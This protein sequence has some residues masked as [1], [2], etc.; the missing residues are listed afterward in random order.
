MKKVVGARA[1]HISATALDWQTS[2]RYPEELQRVVRWKTLIGGDVVPEP[3]VRFGVLEIAPHAGYPDHRHP[4]PEL[5][6]VVSGR[7][8]WTVGDRT[9]TA[10]AGTAVRTPPNTVHRMVNPGDEVLR[11]VWLWWAPGGR[12]DVLDMDSDLVEPVP[13]QPG[14]AGFSGE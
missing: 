1:T 6:Y 13:R 4:S 14:S 11:T 9:F 12:R 10:E 5:Y 8:R 3:D 7:A 2:P